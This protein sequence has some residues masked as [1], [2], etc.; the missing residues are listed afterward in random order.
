MKKLN[1]V[2]LA[3]LS[4]LALT[5]P[6]YADAALPPPGYRIRAAL[7]NVLVPV[8]VA[9][10]IIAIVVLVKVIKSRRGQ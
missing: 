9:V 2:L 6:A 4:M 7:E 3:V 8:I 1:A 10:V 5:L